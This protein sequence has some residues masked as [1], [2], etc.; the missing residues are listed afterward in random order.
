MKRLFI[1][2]IGFVGGFVIFCRIKSIKDD[3][4]SYINDISQIP[5]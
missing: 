3:I 5:D 2:L 1:V 4:D